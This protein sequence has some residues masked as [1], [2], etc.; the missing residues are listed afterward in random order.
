MRAAGRPPPIIESFLAFH[1]LNNACPII[2]VISIAALIISNEGV[3]IRTI[4]FGATFNY[5]CVE[6]IFLLTI[7]KVIVIPATKPHTL[8]LL[9][10]IFQSL[11]CVTADFFRS[12]TVESCRLSHT[13]SQTDMIKLSI[14]TAHFEEAFHG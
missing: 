3:F 4:G 11:S 14:G 6:T 13:S 7:E 5:I 12:I 1:L 10:Y 9:V 8:K 2:G